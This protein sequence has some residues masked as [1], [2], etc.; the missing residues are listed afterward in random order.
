MKAV[1]LEVS[2]LWDNYRFYCRKGSHTLFIMKTG[3]PTGKINRDQTVLLIQNIGNL[4][5]A[6]KASAMFVDLTAA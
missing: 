1:L 5:E 6:K 3:V 4:F 2:H